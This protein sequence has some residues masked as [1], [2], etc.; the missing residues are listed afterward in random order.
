MSQAL[1]YA[2]LSA[3]AGVMTYPM[4]VINDTVLDLKMRLGSLSPSVKQMAITFLHAY[5]VSMLTY[6]LPI[7]EGFHLPS[8]KTKL[9]VHSFMV[10]AFSVLVGYI[11][12]K[13]L[14][15][16]IA[17]YVKNEKLVK[18]DAQ[19]LYVSLGMFVAYMSLYT[20][21]LAHVNLFG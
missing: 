4:A 5:P 21:K 16:F 12:E 15:G 20:S 3:S 9:V 6:A 18:R 19:C 14:E 1:L 17:K 11:L 2:G 13:P 7:G 10:P 8:G